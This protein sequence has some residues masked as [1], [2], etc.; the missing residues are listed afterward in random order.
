MLRSWFGPAA[1]AMLVLFLSAGPV[2][3]RQGAPV[4]PEVTGK[5]PVGTPQGYLKLGQLP[6]SLALLSPPPEG[7]SAALA[8]DE[9]VSITMARP[10]DS[11]RYKLAASDAD[12]HF[13]HA[14]GTF[15]CA[16]GFAPDARTTPVLY[17]LLQKTMIDVGLSTYKAKTRYQR[18]RP[19]VAHNTSTCLPADEGTLRKDGSYP[20]GHSA[21]GW[22]WAL[23]F[24]ELVP[25]RADA[26]LRRG[27]DFGQS[28]LVCNVHWASDV[29]AGRLMASATIARLHAEQAFQK[30]MGAAAHEIAAARPLS[31]G[32]C[33]AETAALTD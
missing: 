9:A 7:G 18:V 4:T 13:P 23:L 33:S 6:D 8:L 21:L 20:S 14:A 26:I 27:R 30:D 31:A 2:A 28:R 15:A 16:A 11:A 24:A 32:A 3:P 29:E 25:N 1:S 19:F 12:L 10:P 17:R 5:L 22:G